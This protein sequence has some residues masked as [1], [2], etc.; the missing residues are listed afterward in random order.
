M[1]KI[2]VLRPQILIGISYIFCHNIQTEN[3][4]PAVENIAG[5]SALMLDQIWCKECERCFF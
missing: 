3:A 2:R 1:K 5:N 4:Q